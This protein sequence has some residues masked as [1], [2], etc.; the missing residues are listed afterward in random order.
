MLE[1]LYLSLHG[2]VISILLSSHSASPCDWPSRDPHCSSSSFS[3]PLQVV[4]IVLQ[5]GTV[6]QNDAGHTWVCPCC[7]D[8][9]GSTL[10][11]NDVRPSCC[12]GL[13][14]VQP[15]LHR[16]A[17]SGQN[18]TDF[19]NEMNVSHCTISEL[20]AC[21]FLSSSG[22][23]FMPHVFLVVWSRI[24]LMLCNRKKYVLFVRF[25]LTLLR[26]IPL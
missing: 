9:V 11:S 5:Q 12:L 6:F 21:S 14:H 23:H 19:H 15:L 1:W 26:R 17:S 3:C 7:Y 10:S 25:G 18:R 8:T 22:A 16:I 2:L 4:S 13:S 24:D 20:L